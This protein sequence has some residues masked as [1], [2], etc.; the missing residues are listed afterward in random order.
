MATNDTNL[1]GVKKIVPS[2]F[3]DHRGFIPKFLTV[4]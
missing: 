1:R 4:K 2:R 3:E